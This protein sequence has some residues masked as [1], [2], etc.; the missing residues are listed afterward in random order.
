MESI[1]ATAKWWYEE[2]KKINKRVINKQ[3]FIDKFVELVDEDWNRNTYA[4]YSGVHV[5][6]RPSRV[7]RKLL[8]KLDLPGLVLPR[9]STPMEKGV[10]FA[11]GM[12][13]EN[14]G[15]SILVYASDRFIQNH[16]EVLEYEV[17]K[18]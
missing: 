10:V 17:D 2:T 1:K 6:A 16:P 14:R 13:K 18:S 15:E 4:K 9:Y 3:S 7:L 5:V 11:H 12:S 8:I